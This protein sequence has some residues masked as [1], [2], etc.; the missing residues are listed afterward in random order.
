MAWQPYDAAGQPI[1]PMPMPHQQAVPVDQIA[2]QPAPQMAALP[3]EQ[4]LQPPPQEYAPIMLTPPDAAGAVATQK[5]VR[6]LPDSRYA[7][8][9]AEARRYNAY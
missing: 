2:V 7:R 6:T 5:V 3:D 8:R 9:R 4:A 1:E